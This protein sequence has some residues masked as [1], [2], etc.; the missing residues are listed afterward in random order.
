MWSYIT[1]FASGAL[2]G[3]IELCREHRRMK[4]EAVVSLWGAVYVLAMG[5]TA[6]VVFLIFG[7]R[8]VDLLGGNRNPSLGNIFLG[9]A[10]GPLAPFI[11]KRMGRKRETGE[12]VSYHEA[13]LTFFRKEVEHCTRVKRLEL[14]YSIAEYWNRD[15]KEL[16]EKALDYIRYIE[17]EK[18][19]QKKGILY[20]ESCG[21]EEKPLEIALFLIDSYGARW[22][23]KNLL[24]E[25]KS[26][27]LLGKE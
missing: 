19:K 27:K 23:K 21:D 11:L 8:V 6:L 16:T 13:L 10:S 20:V 14:A 17:T 12:L 7:P 25:N 18:E 15:V 24:A 26:R 1:S 3:V 22:A 2:F 9:L 5:L 4:T